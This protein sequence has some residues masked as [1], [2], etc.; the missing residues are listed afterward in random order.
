AA[1][2]TPCGKLDPEPGQETGA[3]RRE[4]SGFVIEH[5][6]FA[7]DERIGEIDA[8]PAGK[9]VVANS[10]RTERTCLTGQRAVSRP[11]LERKGDEPVN[12]CNQGGRLKLNLVMRPTSNHGDKPRLCQLREM[13]AR[14]LRRDARRRRKLAGGER[15]AIEKREHHRGSRRVSDQ[16]RD[17]RD[18]G[19]CNHVRYL[20]PEWGDE[21]FDGD[22]SG[23]PGTRW[24]RRSRGP[25]SPTGGGVRWR[26]RGA[27]A[28]APA[29]CRGAQVDPTS[30]S[31]R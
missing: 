15:A 31:R 5:D 7:A 1:R 29:W 3:H 26:P 28:S 30:P 2:R 17:L 9:V 25:A 18:D 21:H 12:Q 24:P 4:L 10:G 19:A 6:V 13:G 20:T 11:F 22:R 14:G 8:E 27:E 16:R 23:T